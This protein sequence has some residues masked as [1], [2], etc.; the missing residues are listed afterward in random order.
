[1]ISEIECL[2]DAILEYRPENFDEPLIK[3]FSNNTE[4]N[5]ENLFRGSYDDLVK[6][7]KI[8]NESNYYS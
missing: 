8:L 1:M 3:K 7:Y 6:L 5:Y 2:I 4:W